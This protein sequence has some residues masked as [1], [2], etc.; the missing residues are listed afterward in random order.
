VIGVRLPNARAAGAPVLAASA[1]AP[2]L[3]A[4]ADGAQQCGWRLNAVV[5]A[6][7]AW[8]HAASKHAAR[9]GG[10]SRDV[11]FVAQ[12][13]ASIHVGR[14]S[15][16]TG[17]AVQLRRFAS[18]SDD[19]SRAIADA[20]GDGPGDVLTFAAID[21]AASAATLSARGWTTRGA[22]DDS[23]VAA[24]KHAEFAVPQLVSA[25]ARAARADRQH[26]LGN[27]ML[28]AAAVLLLAAVALLHWGAHRELDRVRAR[29]AAIADSVAPLLALRDSIA[30]LDARTR[31]TEAV[32]T[33][34]PHWSRTLYE[35]A[36]L[37]PPDAHLTSI[38]ATGDTLVLEA[39]GARAGDVLEA[40]RRSPTLRH[41][42]LQGSVQ[43]EL[44]AGATAAERF[45]IQ[46]TLAPMR[47]RK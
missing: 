9:S 39:E 40:L 5:P 37:L 26:T 14:A 17:T 28:A 24:A 44:E 2:L 29:R 8:L 45:A 31:A 30:Q 42:Q 19:V 4:V 38:N 11:A 46:A 36:L 23:A 6:V 41:V 16:N 35:V 10:A 43:R 18:D 12:E 1:P 22:D 27:R 47:D 7:A 13:G 21:A 20:I 25:R 33:D 34:V 32:L 3:D 15:A